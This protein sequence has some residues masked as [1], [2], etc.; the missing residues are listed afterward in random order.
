M[1]TP[2]YCDDLR[3]KPGF[4][5]C[6][7]SCHEEIRLGYSELMELQYDPVTQEVTHRVCCKVMDW[8]GGI[9]PE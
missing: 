5:G 9:E 1:S 7:E 3:D 2:L 6:C 8:L 4:P